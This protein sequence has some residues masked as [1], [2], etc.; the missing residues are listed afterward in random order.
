MKSII[1]CEGKTDAIL[2]S[3]YLNKVKGWEYYS[4][5]DKRKVHI[6]IRND[7]NEEVNWYILNGN[8]LVI[9]GIGGKDNFKYSINEIFKIIELETEEAFSNIVILTD[10]DEIED[11]GEGEGV[12]LRKFSDYFQ[13]V[14]LKNNE[15]TIKEHINEFKDKLQFKI[16]PII[17]PFDKS[18]AIE[19]F[20]LDAI[21]DMGQEEK[22]IVD[23]SKEFIS[24]FNL[25]NYLNTQRLKI[26]GEF[27]VTLGAMFPQKTFT[28]IDAMLKNINW[29]KYSTIQQGFRKLQEI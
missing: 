7:E 18:G 11:E 4:K 23:K 1:L 29:E 13:G 17:I 9:W 19:T 15:W 20:V 8:L 27:A 6:P 3:Y 21:C 28:P 25:S 14:I 12:V 16:L 22:D 24:E 5:N 26:K 10:R 2:I